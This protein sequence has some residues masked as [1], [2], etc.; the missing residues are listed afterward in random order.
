M[1]SANS[2]PVVWMYSGQGSQYFAMGRAL[3]SCE[4]V[5]RETFDE[6][7][8]YALRWTC[9]PIA[10]VVYDYRGS[11]FDVFNETRFTHPALFAVQYALDRLLRSRGYEPDYVL[12]YSLGE[13]VALATSGALDWRDCIIA[14]MHHADAVQSLPEAGAMLAVLDTPEIFPKL[15]GLFPELELAAVNAP[16]HFVVTGPVE[17]VH[18]A[19]DWL[20]AHEIGSAVLPVS[21]PFHS[22]ALHA[23]DESLSELMAGFRLG[24]IKTPVVSCSAARVIHELPTGLP[25]GITRATIE[26]GKALAAL[27]STGPKLYVDI[28]PSGTLAGFVR[29]NG[30]L[31]PA[32]EALMIMTP[33]GQEHR[34]LA[35]A[36]A[37]MDCV[38]TAHDSV[39]AGTPQSSDGAGTDGLRRNGAALG[40]S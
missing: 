33:F 9:R 27:E 6:I 8:N 23:A 21:H 40:A 34:N 20:T 22:A 31:N 5:F 24:S 38:G 19:K 12:G 16:R 13:F 37:R 10:N 2:L 17:S 28:G 15:V 7:S 35:A 26:F 30:G 18:N 11:Q 25:H 29:H 3:Y 36:Q 39:R 4:P 14:L 32:S 1:S